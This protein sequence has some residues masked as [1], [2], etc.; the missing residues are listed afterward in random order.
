MSD[1]IT[2]VVPETPALL[3]FGDPAK[4]DCWTYARCLDW[5]VATN[6]EIFDLPS[7][8]SGI[9]SGGRILERSEGKKA[10]ESISLK[11]VDRDRLQRAFQN[12]A[13]GYMPVLKDDAGNSVT[14]PARLFIPYI[15][16]LVEDA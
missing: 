4:P 8:A 9:L 1:E 6:P 12:P 10:G 7:G 14:L 3:C 15:Q 2:I 13:S 11:P 5:L 16:T